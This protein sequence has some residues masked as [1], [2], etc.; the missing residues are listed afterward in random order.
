MTLCEGRVQGSVVT[1]RV[2][3]SDT[4]CNCAPSCQLRILYIG[5]HY[6]SD[7]FILMMEYIVDGEML[8]EQKNTM[9]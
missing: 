7:P 1:L 5:E 8:E 3:E 9:R 2:H 6:V 4:V